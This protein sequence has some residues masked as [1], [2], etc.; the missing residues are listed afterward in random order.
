MHVIERAHAIQLIQRTH[1]GE[2]KKQ[3]QLELNMHFG[4]LMR[5]TTNTHLK[6]NT[7]TMHQCVASSTVPKKTVHMSAG[8]LDE[9]VEPM[10]RLQWRQV[11][12]YHHG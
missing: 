10:H 7:N 6:I 8:D 9:G 1:Q 3:V 5:M 4:K 11:Y 2:D 12:A